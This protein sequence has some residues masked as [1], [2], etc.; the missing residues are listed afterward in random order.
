MS[1]RRY[2]R[3]TVIGILLAIP[4]TGIGAFGYQ[5]VQPLERGQSVA[6]MARLAIWFAIDSAISQAPLGACCGVLVAFVVVRLPS[7]AAVV[8]A[9]ALSAACGGVEW[10]WLMRASSSF[11]AELMGQA[12]AAGWGATAIVATS[13]AAA[14]ISASLQFPAAIGVRQ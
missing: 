4:A 6:Q 13:I 9:G 1:L 14:R 8:V 12:M 11:N 10:W 5:L 2:L 3:G 7:V